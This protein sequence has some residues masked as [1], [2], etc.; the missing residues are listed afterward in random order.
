MQK[1]GSLNYVYLIYVDFCFILPMQRKGLEG[2]KRQ[3]TNEEKLKGETGVA[4][5]PAQH[6]KYLAC[7]S[8]E[9]ARQIPFVL[10]QTGRHL[11][12]L[13]PP[14]VGTSAWSGFKTTKPTR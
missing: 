7:D 10:N 5:R 13:A 11:F 4:N 14:S 1:A 3:P 8:I 9:V 6:I 2:D 12:L